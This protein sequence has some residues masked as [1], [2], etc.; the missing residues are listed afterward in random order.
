MWSFAPAAEQQI[1]TFWWMRLGWGD[2]GWC[3]VIREYLKTINAKQSSIL[4]LDYLLWSFSSSILASALLGAPQ[5]ESSSIHNTGTYKLRQ[6]VTCISNTRREHCLTTVI[7]VLKDN[8]TSPGYFAQ[9]WKQTCI[10]NI[11][12]SG[13]RQIRKMS[14]Q[15][16]LVLC[17]WKWKFHQWD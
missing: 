13:I 6:W 15:Q 10:A 16:Q 17:L 14:A 2:V 4:L 1:N 3:V 11:D 9:K 7:K 12:S 8:E 5:Q